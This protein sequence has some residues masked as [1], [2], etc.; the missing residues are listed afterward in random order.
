MPLRGP[1]IIQQRIE[2]DQPR[3]II[4][5]RE[6]GSVNEGRVANSLDKLRHRYLY[7]YRILDIKGVRGAYVIDF[8]I[9]TTPPRSPPLEVFGQYWH[10][11]RIG[12][13]DEFRMRQIQNHF[14]GRANPVVVV[15][16]S[17]TQ[18][19]SDTDSIIR[20]KIGAR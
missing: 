13:E 17:E 12:A 4:Q 7:Q 8:R 9:L 20:Q 6:A 14:R 15:W 16:G 5:G 2:G 11:G 19:Q 1:G 3:D 18:N 10:S